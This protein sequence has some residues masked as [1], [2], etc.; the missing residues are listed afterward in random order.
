MKFFIFEYQID[1]D[2]IDLIQDENCPHF[3]YFLF[4]T[5]MQWKNV[6]LQKEFKYRK[7]FRAETVFTIDPSTAR[8][9]DD[10]LHIKPILDCD[11]AGNPGW[12]VSR[13]NFRGFVCYFVGGDNTVKI[14]GWCSHS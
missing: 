2:L 9:L 13:N 12:E 8:D 7:D 14:A 4:D 1:V 6:C 3:F 10:A 5:Y 11:G